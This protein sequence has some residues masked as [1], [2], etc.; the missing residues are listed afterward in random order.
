MRRRGSRPVGTIGRKNGPNSG[1]Q[2]VNN[3]RRA[4]AYGFA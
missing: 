1:I 3:G 2:A 4:Q